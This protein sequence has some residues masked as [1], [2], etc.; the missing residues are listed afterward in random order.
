MALGYLSTKPNVGPFGVIARTVDTNYR[1][2]SAR[3]YDGDGRKS[4]LRGSV[5]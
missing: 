5:Q 1:P 2:I 4:I 3:N